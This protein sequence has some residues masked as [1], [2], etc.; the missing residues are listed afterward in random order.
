MIKQNNSSPPPPSIL[1]IKKIRALDILKEG[2]AAQAPL[3]CPM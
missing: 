1:L 3:V 2:P